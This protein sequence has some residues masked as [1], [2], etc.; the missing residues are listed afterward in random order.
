M[1]LKGIAASDA[2]PDAFEFL[3]LPPIVET[4]TSFAFLCQTG[5]VSDESTIASL[6]A[7]IIESWN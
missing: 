1:Y 3:L 5:A 7:R 6:S 4:R 2:V